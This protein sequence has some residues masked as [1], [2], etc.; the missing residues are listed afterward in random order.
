ME[1][2]IP[3]SG[4]IACHICPRRY[5]FERS[6]EYPE[7]PRY[8][9]CKQISAHLGELLDPDRIWDEIHCILPDA[10]PE[11]QELFDECIRACTGTAWQR[12]VQ[13]DVTVESDVLGIRGRIDKIFED[14]SFSITRS[15]T[16]P[17]VGVYSTDR[18]RIACYVACLRE[19]LGN[20]ITGGYVEYVASGIS[21]FVEPQP[22]DRRAMIRATRLARMVVAGE[23]PKRPLRAPC[24]DCPYLEPC[25]TGPRKLS[26]LF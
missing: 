3:V 24:E 23:I 19:T 22:R 21:R 2:Y 17:R 14:G 6:K 7:S 8:T 25:T 16:A 10:P 18:L 13:S 1:R 20:T 15:S 4:I 26:D 11:T 5:Y 12:P 9:V